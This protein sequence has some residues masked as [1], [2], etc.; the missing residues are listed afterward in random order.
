[1]V[2][3]SSMSKV[4]IGWSYIQDGTH[5]PDACLLLQRDS[6]KKAM[7]GNGFSLSGKDFFL[8]AVA[9]WAQTLDLEVK[10]VAPPGPISK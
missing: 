3:G 10:N 6:S 7:S 5:E 4:V 8:S 9:G 2:G 1:M